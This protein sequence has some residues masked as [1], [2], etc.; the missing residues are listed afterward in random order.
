MSCIKSK[1]SD[2]GKRS[3]NTDSSGDIPLNE[4]AGVFRYDDANGTPREFVAGKSG[5]VSIRDFVMEGGGGS[6]LEPQNDSYDVG[7][8]RSELQSALKNDP[9]DVVAN[10]GTG[11]KEEFG[12]TIF[13][14]INRNGIFDIS[15]LWPCL[16][17]SIPPVMAGIGLG[18]RSDGPLVGEGF[19][20]TFRQENGSFGVSTEFVALAC[21]LR[22]IDMSFRVPVQPISE[23]THCVVKRKLF[24]GMRTKRDQEIMYNHVGKFRSGLGMTIGIRL[25]MKYLDRLSSKIFE[26]VVWLQETMYIL[27]CPY[28]HHLKYR[29]CAIEALNCRLYSSDTVLSVPI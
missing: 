3:S 24:N 8:A 5:C 1:S 4:R 26:F 27:Y 10:E 14:C 19:G 15:P 9:Y 2:I 25:Q 20:V 22:Y 21:D 29:T 7:G 18:S 16:H 12:S 17:L 11:V 13:S 6:N 28:V 23:L